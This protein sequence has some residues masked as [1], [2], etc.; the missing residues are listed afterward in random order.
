M[1]QARHGA[2]VQSAEVSNGPAVLEGRNIQMEVLL[3]DAG[4]G[5]G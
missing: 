5:G 4:P 3:R 2:G 1:P